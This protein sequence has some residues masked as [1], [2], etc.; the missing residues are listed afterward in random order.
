MDIPS[1]LGSPLLSCDETEAR[2]NRNLVVFDYRSYSVRSHLVCDRL[3]ACA[4]TSGRWSSCSKLGRTALTVQPKNFA[5]LLR[6]TGS[7]IA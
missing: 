6:C 1:L 4:S 5:K 3:L 2:L 7:R